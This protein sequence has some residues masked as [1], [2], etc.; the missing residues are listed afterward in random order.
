MPNTLKIRKTF[1][2]L[3]FLFGVN[4]LIK[5]KRSFN[6]FFSFLKNLKLKQYHKN[7][8][9]LKKSKLI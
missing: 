3:L 4:N 7:S 2:L 9:N 8:D 5:A 1:L 6:H